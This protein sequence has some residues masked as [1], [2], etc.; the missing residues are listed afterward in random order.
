MRPA[1]EVI[2]AQLA[3]WETP[4]VE[5]DVFGTADPERIAAAVDGFARAELGA[6]VAGY[7]FQAASIGSVH[8]VVL[9]DGRQVVLKVRPHERI[10]RPALE[11]V[12]AAQRRLA[13]AGF[14]APRPLLGPTP[15]GEGL[16]TVEEYLPRGEP[17]DARAP[18]VRAIL[19]RGLVEH[20]R[21]LDGAAAPAEPL[22]ALFPAPHGKIFR[23]SEPDTVWV[24][25]LARRARAIADAVASPEVAGHRDWRVEHVQL[26]DGAIVA[27]YDW[28]SLGRV[29]ETRLV[30][31]NA[32]GYTCDWSGDARRV[33]PTLDSVRAFIADYE[34]ARGAPLSAD[35]RRAARAW[36][37]YFIAYG[38]W[39]SIRPGETE[40][41]DDTW[42]AVLRAIGEKLLT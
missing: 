8:G 12:V 17:V 34:Q 37:A 9:D 5:L 15:L 19:A 39:I 14:P 3:E 21:L 29:P 16:A 6:G 27:T 20:V 1:V 7:L 42:P 10:D 40:W 41:P 26:R 13:A 32:H 28:D 38:A 30:G 36:C 23:P 25:D 33:L 31:S 22:P 4:F 35:E 18:E 11:A 2:A 24:R